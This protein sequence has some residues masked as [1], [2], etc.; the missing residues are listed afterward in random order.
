MRFALILLAVLLA[1]LFCFP[2]R[3]WTHRG[4]NTSDDIDVRA[5]DHEARSG[6]QSNYYGT[7]L[8]AGAWRMERG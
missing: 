7:G 3:S 2:K 8:R 4:T 5:Q 6:G 1:C